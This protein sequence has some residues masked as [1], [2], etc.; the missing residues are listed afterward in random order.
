MLLSSQE[1]MEVLAK[2]NGCDSSV[3]D[4]LCKEL[5]N[6]VDGTKSTLQTNEDPIT[7]F[8]KHNKEKKKLEIVMKSEDRNSTF[9]QISD[10]VKIPVEKLKLIHKGRM[11]MPENI[12]TFL[13]HRALF[14]AFG[15]VCECEDGLDKSDIDVLMKQLNVERNVA[16]KALR[17]TGTLL[18]AIFD[19]GNNL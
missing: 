1:E 4:I 2:Q 11:V 14:L 16:V 8:I 5:D 15:E 9:Q 13:N 18:D 12:H 19:I 10:F 6:S 3:D 17:Q 7:I